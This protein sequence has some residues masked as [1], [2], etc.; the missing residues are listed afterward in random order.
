MARPA[1]RLFSLGIALGFVLTF[2]GLSSMASAQGAPGF[3]LGVA[4]GAIFP[5]ENQSDVYKTGWSGTLLFVWNFGDSPFGIRLDGSYGELA[6]KDALVPFFDDGNT[7][8]LDGTFDVVIGPHI[9]TYVQPYILGGVGGYDLRFHGQEV[10]TGNVFS[11]STT[12]FGWNAGTGIAFRLGD[13]TNAHLF[14][15]GRYT[16]IS[17]DTDLFT[18][19]IHT[20]GTRFTM[21]ML[22]TGIVF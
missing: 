21:V 18:N 20:G 16:S 6:T 10:D 15:E 9:G 11:N 13:T 17:L 7:R 1:P 14:I 2:F 22:N 5:V 19:S 3:H 8:V 4:G 12:R